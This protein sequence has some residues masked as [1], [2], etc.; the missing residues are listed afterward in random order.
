MTAT[1]SALAPLLLVSKLHAYN[2]SDVKRLYDLFP[3]PQAPEN[4]TGSH[5]DPFMW[6]DAQNNYHAITHNQ[7]S[8]NLCAKASHSCGAHL[9]SRDS[10]T[11]RISKNFV[12]NSSVPLANG[13]TGV[14]QTRQRPQLV[15]SNDSERRP[16]YLYNGASF[17]GNNGD[18]HM[19]THTMAFRFQQ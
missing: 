13:T 2:L 5:E 16:L 12:Y 1:S 15:L 10:F 7:G 4:G 14:L 8:G 6:Q 9:F 11:W 17:E 3:Q 18:L 19:L